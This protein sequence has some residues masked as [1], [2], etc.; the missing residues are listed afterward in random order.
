M[1]EAMKV[2]G[3]LATIWLVVFT[4]STAILVAL[5]IFGLI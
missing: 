3:G 1:G 5:R 2:L 4:A